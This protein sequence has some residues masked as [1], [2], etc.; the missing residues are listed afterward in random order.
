MPVGTSLLTNYSQYNN[1][2]D[3]VKL[4]GRKSDDPEVNEY[5]NSYNKD[6]KKFIKDKVLHQARCAEIR[7]I[8]LFMKQENENNLDGI[9][10]L[11]TDTAESYLAYKFLR[12]YFE[13]YGNNI[14]VRKIND[15][16]YNDPKSFQ[17]SG[18]KNL[19]EQLKYAVTDARQNK[20][21]PIINAT[22][23]FKAE[24]AMLLLMAQFLKID[25]FYVH[26]L[27]EDQTVVFPHLPVE[28]DKS[29]WEDWKSVI[30]AVFDADSSNTGVMDIAE[31]KELTQYLDRDKAGFLFEI[32]EE[33]G[34]VSL[35][36][37]G[38][39]IAESFDLEL[40]SLELPNSDV[41]RKKRLDLNKKEMNHAPKGSEQFM[42]KIAEL[43]FVK[44]IKNIRLE[45]TAESRLKVK[46]DDR[47]PGEVQLTH[48]DGEKGL[49][50]VV[51]TTA[52]NQAEHKYAKELIAKHV[53]IKVL[54]EA[55]PNSYLFRSGELLKRSFNN[56]I[57]SIGN[58]IENAD[59]IISKGKELTTPFENKIDKQR[60][61]LKEKD[62]TIKELENE[63]KKLIN[64][65]LENVDESTLGE[66]G[67]I[68]LDAILKLKNK[69][70]QE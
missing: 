41:D 60:K 69:F 53:N 35:S 1:K 3:Y 12:D 39:L 48:S 55:D 21:T 11:P 42:R 7:S 44:K 50:I 36:A 10:M 16:S 5:Y 61:K 31:F 68:T 46:Y 4:R 38:F 67:N 51:K 9:T 13:K 2:F 66:G 56:D 6:I 59:E 49:G 45:H 20:E 34:G 23:G 54:D 26:E 24:S 28:L 17:S 30:K 43:N 37:L 25:V 32:N 15:L 27:M 33:F 57:I 8:A 47:D 58:L 19:L 18:L 40:E 52:R 64:T 62:K 22:P 63:I 70:G 14:N 29:F 65:N